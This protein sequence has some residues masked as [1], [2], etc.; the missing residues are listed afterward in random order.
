M[1]AMIGIGGRRTVCRASGRRQF[2]ISFLAEVDRAI[3][4]GQIGMPSRVKM[5]LIAG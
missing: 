2:Q 4:A 5:C 3:A 1:L